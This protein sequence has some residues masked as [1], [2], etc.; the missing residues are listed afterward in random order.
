MWTA[1]VPRG[2]SAG[3]IV[4]MRHTID[5]QAGSEDQTA[6]QS[7]VLVENFHA[8]ASSKYLVAV[9]DG[10]VERNM[11]QVRSPSVPHRILDCCQRGA[12]RWVVTTAVVR[13]QEQAGENGV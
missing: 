8:S 11:R 7:A 5:D 12:Q 9:P 10:L 2:A 6:L 1:K 3:D 4:E 13:L